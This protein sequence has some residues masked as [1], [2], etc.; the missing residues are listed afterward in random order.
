MIQILK[1]RE[2]AELGVDKGLRVRVVV[3]VSILNVA[4]NIVVVSY[5]VVLDV[6]PH[7][8]VVD[9]VI[10]VVI[11]VSHVVSNIVVVLNMSVDLLGVVVILDVFG[12]PI[13][14]V[15]ERIQTLFILL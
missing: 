6:V 3:V 7:V 11:N 8:V 12:L 14:S 4:S 10:V 1:G 5:V 15:V 2:I 9:V 13:L